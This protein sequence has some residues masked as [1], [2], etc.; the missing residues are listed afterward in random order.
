M[1]EFPKSEPESGKSNGT[2]VPGKEIPKIWVYVTSKGCA[3]FWKFLKTLFHP[4]L[5]ISGNSNQSFR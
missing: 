5:E 1:V 2:E 4:S 3:L